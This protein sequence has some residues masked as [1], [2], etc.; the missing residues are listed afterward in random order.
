MPMTLGLHIQLNPHRV[1]VKATLSV[2]DIYNLPA[3]PGT[4]RPLK[5]GHRSQERKQA[6]PPA[7]ASQPGKVPGSG[8]Q[9]RDREER[10][11]VPQLENCPTLGL[12]RKGF[13]CP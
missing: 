3:W 13:K 1:R 5:L 4:W 9:I 7:P 6:L 12:S 8:T 11:P 2:G 10:A